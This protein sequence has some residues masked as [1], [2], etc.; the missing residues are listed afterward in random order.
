MNLPPE[1]TDALAS[2]LIMLA[3]WICAGI[4]LIGE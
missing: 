3:L 4:L 1:S 2:C